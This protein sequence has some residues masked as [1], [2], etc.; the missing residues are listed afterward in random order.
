MFKIKVGGVYHV[1]SEFKGRCNSFSGNAK[2]VTIRV[3][4]LHDDDRNFD[5]DILDRQKNKVGDCSSP[6]CFYEENLIIEKNLYNLEVGDV[7]YRDS[8]RA[9]VLSVLPSDEKNPIYFL[10]KNNNL[11]DLDARPYSAS[12]LEKS[13]WKVEQPEGAVQEMTVEEVSKLVGKTVKIVESKPS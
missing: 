9:A 10:S 7:I 13:R 5:Y 1:K 2:A 12:E 4:R 3:T 11:E 6:G 8:I